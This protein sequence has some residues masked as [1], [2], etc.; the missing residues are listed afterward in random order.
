MKAARIPVIFVDVLPFVT[1]G[2]A[3]AFSLPRRFVAV[4]A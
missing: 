3:Y 1:S 2:R 4:R